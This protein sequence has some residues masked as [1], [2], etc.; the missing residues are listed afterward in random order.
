MPGTKIGSPVGGVT[1][2]ATPAIV[3]GGLA[4]TV[5][6]VNTSVPG[7]IGNL[8]SRVSPSSTIAPKNAASLSAL[9]R[10][11]ASLGAKSI[12]GEHLFFL[13]ANIST[14]KELKDALV[15]FEDA[16]KSGTPAVL[17]S[18][19]GVDST[20]AAI[21]AHLGGAN[22]LLIE[23]RK[24]STGSSVLAALADKSS[25]TN[26]HP[27]DGLKSDASG[28]I[29]P[30]HMHYQ[31]LSQ[32]SDSP[33]PASQSGF[34]EAGLN[35]LLL[36]SGVKV[37]KGQVDLVKSGDQMTPQI[38]IG[39]KTVEPQPGFK[40]DGLLGFENTAEKNAP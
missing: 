9:V 27:K 24:A 22:V 13:G 39:E 5:R 21:K 36:E 30:A 12:P 32:L 23:T 40:F 26:A 15:D 6:P 11:Q 3:P 14:P 8:S 31:D 38:K 2:I 37:A 28:V 10:P 35:K 18:G 16:Q 19:G 34:M 29:D 20:M 25:P 33:H 7:A 4:R 1:N 17:I